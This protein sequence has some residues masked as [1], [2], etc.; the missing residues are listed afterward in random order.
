MDTFTIVLMIV[1]LAVALFAR[2]AMRRSYDQALALRRAENVPDEI[3]ITRQVRETFGGV[4]YSGVS[5]RAT[6]NRRYAREQAREGLG[7]R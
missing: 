7:V 4:P 3:T 2:W 1:V 6:V 5:N